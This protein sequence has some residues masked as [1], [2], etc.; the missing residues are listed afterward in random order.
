MPKVFIVSQGEDTGGVAS[1]ILRAVEAAQREHGQR[2]WI[3]RS[4]RGNDNYIGYPPDLTWKWDE[5]SKTCKRFDEEYE[6]ADLIHAME[7]VEN[8]LSI[9]GLSEPDKP[10][11]VH[12][13]GSALR[14]KPAFAPWCEERKIPQIASTVDLEK[15]HPAIRWMPN[16]IPISFLAE[17]G[18]RWGPSDDEPFN[19]A[20]TPTFRECK[21][22]DIFLEGAKLAGVPVVI[23]E[24][25][26]W[27]G[28]LVAKARSHAYMDQL[29][30]GF[31]LS[32]LEAWSMGRPVISSVED[33]ATLAHMKDTW[34]ELP[35]LYV[36]PNPRSIAD[37]LARLRDDPYFREETAAKGYQFVLK[38]HDEAFVGERLFRLWAR[39]IGRFERLTR[40]RS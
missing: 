33:P 18:H 24:K 15:I 40:K 26:R 20:H 5:D 37:A 38:H 17:I 25:V 23:T 11:V 32:A 2:G 4:M 28:A 22:T 1:A 35:F 29:S 7:R 31:G 14:W 3:V 34:G 39:T 27:E 30:F 6:N 12:H 16:P 19:V 10:Y 21:G 13:H 9:R 36:E 8:I